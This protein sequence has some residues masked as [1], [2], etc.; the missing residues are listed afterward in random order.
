MAAWAHRALSPSHSWETEAQMDTVTYYRD[1]AG[2][3]ISSNFNFCHSAPHTARAKE[4]VVGGWHCS[5]SVGPDRDPWEG[6]GLKKGILLLSCRIF[7]WGEKRHAS[8]SF[9]LARPPCTY[10]WDLSGLTP[11]LRHH[12]LSNTL[13]PLITPHLMGTFQTYQE[14]PGD[15]EQ[16]IHENRTG[17]KRERREKKKETVLATICKLTRNVCDYGAVHL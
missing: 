12:F 13:T 2:L 14:R 4:A 6:K 11:W 8:R 15:P 7:S 9:P 10:Q 5:C 3:K 17:V 16:H 1:M